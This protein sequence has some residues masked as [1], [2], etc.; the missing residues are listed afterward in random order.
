MF[1][2]T[3][4]KQEELVMSQI[5][6]TLNFEELKAG[7]MDSDLN[8]VLKSSVVLLLNE[9]MKKERDEYMNNQSYDRMQNRH[10]YRNGYY[11]RDFFL[12][13]GKVQ[14]KV[15]RTRSGNFE[16][17]VFDL[18]QRSDQAL[19]LSMTE[20]V[21]N[22]VSTRKVT[23]IVNQ[24]CGENVSKSFVSDLT[25]KLDPIVKEWAE[26]PLNTTYFPYIYAD[27]MYIK[28]REDARVVSKGVYI[29][30][31]VRDDGK[32]EIIGLQVDHG[33]S[34]ENWS[35]FFDSLIGRGLQS[36]KVIISDAHEG[37]KL[38]IQKKFIGTSWQRCTVHFKRNI[39]DKMPRKNSQDAKVFFKSI[40][41]APTQK[42]ARQIKEEFI[43]QYEHDK[44]YEKAIKALD[45]GFEDTVQYYAE[46]PETHKHI[47]STN[48]LERLN[49]EIR[50]RE[51]VIR[52]FPNQQSAFRLIGAVLMDQEKN[53]D[54]GNHKYIKFKN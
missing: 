48:V 32:R 31:G 24:L 12:S 21:V 30:L 46:P 38:A 18:Y 49:S 51:R 27:A 41:D 9:Y 1:L 19:L 34:E 54:P 45:D 15:P 6:L 53:M 40:Y 44:K 4:T 33:E 52:V 47:R 35:N 43:K 8:E 7:I 22:G 11:D 37:L 28:V 14:L 10:D 16:T 36:P 2:A 39:I 3:K 20:M 5:N 25:K 50:R 29:A 42:V 17:D 13:I 23:N 26:R